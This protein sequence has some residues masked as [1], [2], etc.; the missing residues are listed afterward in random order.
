M[1]LGILAALS[2]YPAYLK[3]ME[4]RGADL[5]WDGVIADSEVASVLERNR[6]SLMEP[7]EW[8]F[9]V[10]DYKGPL[11]YQEHANSIAGPTRLDERGI[12]S[13]LVDQTINGQSI[14]P[15]SADKCIYN[16]FR[17][18]AERGYILADLQCEIKG[19]EGNGAVGTAKLMFHFSKLCLKG[20]L[21]WQEAETAVANGPIDAKD[22]GYIVAF[23][24]SSDSSCERHGDFGEPG[25]ILRRVDEIESLSRNR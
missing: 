8:L 21:N 22:G 4:V 2:A 16:K 9:L 12:I 1:T 24:A 10:D 20:S 19:A 13:F 15:K 3:I 5:N 23:R 17:L 14:L 11:V 25:K 18:D 7:G 6:D